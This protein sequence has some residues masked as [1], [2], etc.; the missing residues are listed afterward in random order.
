VVCGFGMLSF[1]LA[2]QV[3]YFFGCFKII[4]KEERTAYLMSIYSQNIKYLFIFGDFYPLDFSSIE[5]HNSGFYEYSSFEK[6]TFPHSNKTIFFATEFKG[7]VPKANINAEISIFDNTCS[8]NKS[9]KQAIIKDEENKHE[10]EE[11]IKEDFITFFNVLYVNRSFFKKSEN[12]FRN[13]K[14]K[15]YPML[16]IDDYL[17]FFIDTG[18]FEKE[19]SLGSDSK[20]HYSVSQSYKEDVRYLLTNNNFTPKLKAIYKSFL[21]SNLGNNH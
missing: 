1:V 9:L 15:I 2:Q 12:I 7:I 20:Y 11:R 16:S 13:K 18:V 6:S 14:G 8:I 3:Y 5:I 10:L 4:T 19:K 17:F 21:H